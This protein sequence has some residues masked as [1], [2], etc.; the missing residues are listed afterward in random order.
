[1]KGGGEGRGV[2]LGEVHE[3]LR[4]CSYRNCW[5]LKKLY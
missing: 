2:Q 5:L 1:M 4:I 3:S